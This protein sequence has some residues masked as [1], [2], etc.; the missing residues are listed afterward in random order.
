MNTTETIRK[1][2]SIRK[3]K[4][5]AIIP[6]DDIKTILEAAMFAPSACNTRPWEFIVLKSEQAK[7][8]AVKIHP[9]AKHLNDASIGIIVCAK[10]ELQSGISKGFFPQDCG[11]AVQNILLQSLELGYGSCWCGIY[12]GEN[13]VPAFKKNFNI[14]CTPIALV[15]I[16]IAD[17]IPA[18]RGF[19]DENKVTVL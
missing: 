13:C 19:Y 16:G 7:Q 4:R 18:V 14:S 6:D 3:Y 15:V 9:Y 1:R 12:P 2:R 5:G 10:T 11:A 17:E 8:T